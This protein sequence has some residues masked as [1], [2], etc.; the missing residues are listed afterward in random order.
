MPQLGLCAPNGFLG[1]PP[2]SDEARDDERV[3]ETHFANFYP[4]SQVLLLS[5]AGPHA[6]RCIY[7]TPTRSDV[8]VPCG[9]SVPARV[10]K[11]NGNGEQACWSWTKPTTAQAPGR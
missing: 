3:L 1:L 10:L 9:R 8:T 2:N 4:A 11:P 7:V 5:Q 6:S